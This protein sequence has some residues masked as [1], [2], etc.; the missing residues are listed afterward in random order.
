MVARSGKAPALVFG[1]W[2]EGG[3]TPD[4][5][6]PAGL[7]LTLVATGAAQVGQG[8]RKISQ[9]SSNSHRAMTSA[10]ADQ[11]GEL[12]IPFQEQGAAFH[13]G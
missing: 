10:S 4:I 6:A 8:F 2:G 9:D 7:I 3:T 12:G 1:G 11:V 5:P 13:T